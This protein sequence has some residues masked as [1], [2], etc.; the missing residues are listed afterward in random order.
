MDLKTQGVFSWNE[1]LTK[2]PEAAKKFYTEVI[3]WTAEDMPSPGGT[4][5]IF[6]VNGEQVAGL[7]KLPDEAAQMGAQPMWG[8]YI[9]V[10]DADA[11]AA[12]VE[13]MGGKILQPPMDIE[14]IGRFATLQDPQGAVFSI[15]KAAD[16]EN[17]G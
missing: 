4:Y 7:M 1:L 12:R 9:S 6:K 10:D 13:T 11:V 16:M 2:D 5:T 17:E 14:G 15:L 3:G 8:A